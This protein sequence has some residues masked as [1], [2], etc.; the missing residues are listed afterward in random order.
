MNIKCDYCGKDAET[1]TG[2]DI[3]PHREDLHSLK[4]FACYPCSAW[5]GCHKK[6]GK[7]LGRLADKELRSAKMSA[8]AA[9][10]PLWRS[11]DMTRSEA[12]A[13]LANELCISRDNC[14]IGMFNKEQC[15][16]VVDACNKM[17][18]ASVKQ[19]WLS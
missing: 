8:H 17:L 11:G 1:A 3:Y 6:T 5:V 15:G 14:H 2:K 13:W 16:A 12:Y 9:F 4:F 7:P 10:D 18:A 19:G